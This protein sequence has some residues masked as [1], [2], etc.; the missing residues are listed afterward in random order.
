MLRKH[1]DPSLFSVSRKF[2]SRFKYI[3]KQKSIM[4]PFVPVSFN[5]YLLITNLV[6]AVLLVSHPNLIL[7]QISDSI[8][9]FIYKYFSISEK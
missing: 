7:K 3:P 5:N 4:N 1:K 9:H 6:L 8:S 2:G